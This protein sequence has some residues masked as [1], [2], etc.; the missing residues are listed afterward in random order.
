MLWF[1]SVSYVFGCRADPLMAKQAK[2]QEKRAFKVNARAHI[3]YLVGFYASNIYKIWV[4]RLDRII[5]TRNVCFD[6][7][8]FYMSS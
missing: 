3:K 5:V 2:G 4:S 6:E 7:D 8:L 1:A